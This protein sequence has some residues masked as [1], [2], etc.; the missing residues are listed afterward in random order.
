M[1][2]RRLGKTGLDVSLLS[3]GG[4]PLGGCYGDN[5]EKRHIDSVHHAVE[6]GIN[7]FDTSPYYG[8]T[9]SETVMGKA[10]KDIPRDKF[11][12]ATKVGRYDV[13]D[14]DFSYNRVISSVKES[15]KRLNVE[16]LD[17]AMCHDIEFGDLN[18]VINESIPALMKLKQDGLV[19]HIGVT[20]YPLKALMTVVNACPSIDVILSYCHFCLNDTSLESIVPQLKQQNIGIINAS[21]LN[22]GMLTERGPPEWHPAD[23]EIK[24]KAQEAARLCKERGSDISKV[25]LQYALRENQDIHTHLV[26][27]PHNDQ[28]DY[29]IKLMKDPIDNDLTV[30]VLNMFEGVKNR[31]WISGRTENN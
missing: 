1:E 17:V 6:M 9:L 20:G 29:N 12:L 8:K 11:I 13:K 5:D 10:I 3:Y 19:R 30:N 24:K 27:M 28:V 23:P 18:Q 16:Y 31:Q 25:A 4:S 22:M 26:G 2:Y 21:L 15:M 14:F 7:F